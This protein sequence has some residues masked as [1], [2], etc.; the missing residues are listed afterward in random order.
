MVTAIALSLVVFVSLANVETM[1][2]AR[3]AVR[4]AVDEGARAGARADDPQRACEARARAVL[5]GLLAPTARSA[6]A[7]TCR[8][9]ASGAWIEARADAALDP[10]WPGLPAWTFTTTSTAGREVLP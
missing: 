6:V 4:A 5:D 8:G 2:F 7:V 3:D 1:L 10:W 9:G